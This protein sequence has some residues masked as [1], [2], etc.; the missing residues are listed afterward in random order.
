ML[1]LRSLACYHIV[2]A[3]F[4]IRAH[5]QPWACGRS[6]YSGDKM[7]VEPYDREHVMRTLGEAYA[8]WV[9]AA[10]GR[11]QYDYE[12]E[13]WVFPSPTITD[14]GE[15][16]ALLPDVSP[17]EI[18]QMDYV[19]CL[20]VPAS[21]VVPLG[22]VA[23]QA[24]FCGGVSLPARQYWGGPFF[25][26]LAWLMNST[27]TALMAAFIEANG[28]T[29]L[30]SETVVTDDDGGPYAR[31]K[32]QV[33]GAPKDVV[34][35]WSRLSSLWARESCPYSEAQYVGPGVDVLSAGGSGPMMGLGGI[36]AALKD[37]AMQDTDIAMN[38]GAA[39]YSVRSK[40]VTE[41]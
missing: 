2:V 26:H 38:N 1:T 30:L 19:L 34:V 4:P 13:Q 12:T 21:L 23:R 14:D 35:V 22:Y 24:P 3:R 41:P 11:V 25:E 29:S 17:P 8:W 15:Y 18:H 27:H 9:E 28:W 39:V 16:L 31:L 20:D 40:E 32:V 37:L 7:P 10:W 36:E 6:G 5:R 33:L